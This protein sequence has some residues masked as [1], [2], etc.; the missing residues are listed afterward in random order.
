MKKRKA[1][2]E[3]KETLRYGPCDGWSCLETTHGL[4]WKPT[5]LARLDPNAFTSQ[6]GEVPDEGDVA[7]HSTDG[8]NFRGRW[9]WKGREGVAE[10]VLYRSSKGA[11]FIGRW[12]DRKGRHG[13][14]FIILEF[15][16]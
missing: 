2:Q 15:V 5:R 11:A 14:W 13:R 16:D 9:D 3:E 10:F 12:L 8:E 7:V 4:Q 1:V 6:W